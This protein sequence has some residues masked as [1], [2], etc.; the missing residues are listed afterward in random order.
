M[1]KYSNINLTTELVQKKNILNGEA[2]VLDN[3]TSPFLN[4]IKQALI[5]FFQMQMLMMRSCSNM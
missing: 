4:S 3:I 1:E 2:N 5:A